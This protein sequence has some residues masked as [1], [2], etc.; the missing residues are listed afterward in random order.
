MAHVDEEFW[1]KALAEFEGDKRRPGLWAR[2]FSD[3]QGDEAVAK[4]NYLKHRAEELSDEHHQ[5][6][7]AQ[8][9]AEQDAIEKA[10]LAKLSEE[11]RAYDLLPKG[12]CPN[13]EAV[14]PMVSD[15]CPKCRA[16]FS[17]GGWKVLPIE[18]T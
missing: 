13:C 15:E 10:K 16:L 14:I 6:V 8:E 2:V 11:Q 9:R 12:H 5:H 17:S 3:A 18:N 7:L 1:A 4:A